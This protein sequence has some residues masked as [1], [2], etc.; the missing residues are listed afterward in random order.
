MAAALAENVKKGAADI[1]ETVAETD[2]RSEL[3]SFQ[4]GVEEDTQRTAAEARHASLEAVHTLGSLGAL[5]GLTGEWAGRVRDRVRGAG[6]GGH[7]ALE[8]L[9]GADGLDAAR[10]AQSLTQV[11]SKLRGFGASL[12]SGTTGLLEKVHDTIS[13]ELEGMEDQLTGRGRAGA[14]SS[15][16]RAASGAGGA[17][18]SRLEAEVSAMQRNSGTYCDEPED[19]SDYAAWLA[20]FDLA[21]RRSEID[22]ITAGNA[23]MAELQARIVPLIV[24]YDVFWTRYFYQLHRLQRQHEARQQLAQRAR[25]SAQEDAI[26]WDDDLAPADPKPNSDPTSDAAPAAPAAPA[27]AGAQRGEGGPD[28]DGGA[29][30]TAQCGE[31]AAPEVPADSA[32][33][34][35]EVR[36]LPP[37]VA[38][39]PGQ[40]PPAAAAGSRTSSPVR[41]KEVSPETSTASDDSGATPWTVVLGVPPAIAEGGEDLEEIS[42]ADGAAAGGADSDVD[43][44]W[45][46]DWN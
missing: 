34:S 16:A 3:Q 32:A 15:S 7:P 37:P 6:E 10:V 26:G 8:G 24:Q 11:S 14:P 2:W 5:G 9:N 33:E 20:G 1:A 46:E 22:E 4:H 43:E 29:G 17:R 35:G 44:D 36:P 13:A 40:A 30:N 23:F 42:D 27:A 18:Y 21:A 19:T 38:V 41:R 31:A 12:L 39:K 28:S 25:A 45:G